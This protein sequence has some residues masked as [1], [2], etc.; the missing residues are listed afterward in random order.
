MSARR[1]AKEAAPSGA[2]VPVVLLIDDE[3]MLLEALAEQLKESC[4]LY[5]ALSP[6]EAEALL[7]LRRYDVIVCDHNLPGEQGLDFLVRTREAYPDMHRILIT[8]YASPE[9]IAMGKELAG[10]AACLVKPVRAAKIAD[11]IRAATS[12]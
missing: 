10:L 1:P 4:R 9:F 11:A 12:G 5:T 7:R 8:G 2:A 3:P 6:V